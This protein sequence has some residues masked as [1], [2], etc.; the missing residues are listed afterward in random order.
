M[1]A[2]NNGSITIE[3]LTSL[4]PDAILLPIHARSK[5]PIYKWPKITLEQ[6]QRP[7]YRQWLSER[8][9]TGVVLGTKSQHLCAIDFDNDEAADLFLAL[10]PNFQKTLRSRGR[11]GCQ[12]WIIADGD[13]PHYVRKL[14]DEDGKAFG[15]WRADGGQSIIRGTH[16]D[17]GEHYRLLCDLPPMPVW[18]DSIRWPSYLVL[19]WKNSPPKAEGRASSD[20]A[21]PDLRKRILAYIAKVP[22]A[23][24][25][26][27]GHD[28]TFKLA[29]SLVNG[30][31]LSAVEALPYLEVFNSRCEPRWT[32]K[33]LAHKLADAEK[34]QHDKP[35]GHLLEEQDNRQTGSKKTSAKQMVDRQRIRLPRLDWVDSQFADA[36][37]K[38]LGSLAVVFRCD[39]R[40]VEVD[41]EEFSGELDRAKLALGGLKFNTLTPVRFKTWIE[42]FIE[43]GIDAEIKGEPK[44]VFRAKS[45]SEALARWVLASPQFLKHIPRI[46]RILDVPIPIRTKSGK[47][48]FPAAGFNRELGVYC[49]PDAPVLRE[50]PLE[51]A[52]AILDKAYEGFCWKSPQAKTHAVARLITPYARGLMFFGERWP[53]WFYVANRPRAGKDYCNGVTQIVYLGHAFEDTPITDKHEETTKRIVSASRAGRRMMHFANCQHHLNDPGFIQAITGPTINARSLGSNDAKSDLELPNEID[54]SLSANV[55]LTYREDVEPRLRK[56][57]LEFFEEDANKRTFPNPF[58]HDWL[59]ENRPQVISAIHSLFLHWIKEGQPKGQTSFSSFPHWAE[60]VGGVMVTCGLG[61]PCLPH[62]G[63]DL[64]GGDR[65]EIAMKALF[66]MCFEAFPEQQLKKRDI[67]DLIIGERENN[68]RLEWFGILDGD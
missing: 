11:I 37:G 45:M 6:S 49:A 14:K 34:A 4:L 7:R 40:V 68:E 13:Y 8:T 42:Q 22:A 15:E 3:R 54:Y 33:E 17:T 61:D 25:G 67:Y 10:N 46:A 47:I 38:V 66:E 29:C 39:D 63:E 20:E 21:G 53:L 43:T 30:W 1:S 59:K 19:P 24:S 55:G 44:P 65:R 18:F 52:R 51:E 9:N 27:G 58:L 41:D 60:V 28:Q 12:F 31:A 5:G 50:L 57:E 2:S 62:E 26:N 16:K 48:V 35:R 23:V 56:I 32:E 36:V 64:I